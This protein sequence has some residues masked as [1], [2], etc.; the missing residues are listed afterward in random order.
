MN[1]FTNAKFFNYKDY[2]NHVEQDLEKK[3]QSEDADSDELIPY[4]QLNQTRMNRLDKTIALPEDVMSELNSLKNTYVFYVISE[5]WCGDAAQLVPI[6]N[7]M[8]EG[9]PTIDLRIILRDDNLDIMDQY[10]TNVSRSI[11]K[12][13]IFD[14]NGNEVATWGPRP[15]PAAQLVV[16]LKGQYG[17]ITKEVKEGL[18]RW[19]NT[20]KGY[21]TMKEILE[22]IK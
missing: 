16:D 20:D 11:P 2:R 12:L 14:A 9:A 22:L 18:Q 10:L 21:T 5:G 19:Y 6:I 7:C 17:G 8:V 4:I 1:L 13:I 15:K 3:L